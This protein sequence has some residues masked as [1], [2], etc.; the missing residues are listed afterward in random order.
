[1]ALGP[2]GRLEEQSITFVR[3]GKGG[4]FRLPETAEV[5]DTAEMGGGRGGR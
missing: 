5:A 3:G 4:C 1:M 2:I